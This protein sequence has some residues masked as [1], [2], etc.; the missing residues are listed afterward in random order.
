MQL[1]A[2][3]RPIM[4]AGP[5]RYLKLVAY[6]SFCHSLLVGIVTEVQFSPKMET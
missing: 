2:L 3:V 5:E 6:L 1:K 4:V